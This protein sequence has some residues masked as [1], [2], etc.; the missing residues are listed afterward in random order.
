MNRSRMIAWTLVLGQLGVLCLTLGCS[1]RRDTVSG[2]VFLVTLG[3]ENVKL[4]LVEVRAIPEQAISRHLE[5]RRQQSDSACAVIAPRLTAARA[6]L[7]QA[8]SDLKRAPA[9][10]IAQE[11]RYIK[12]EITLEQ[13]GSRDAVIA[14]YRHAAEI[15]E[16][17]FELVD[18]EIRAAKSAAFML[19]GL[20]AGVARATTDADG[21]FSLSVPRGR[22]LA[23]AARA[24][25]LT[26]LGAEQSSWLFWLPEESRNGT[27]L[28]LSNGNTTSAGYPASLIQAE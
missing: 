3:R 27:P 17:R 15:A 26:F 6:L 2:Q 14:T 16:S 9:L 4:G 13:F 11:I 23:I 5:I 12:S 8:Q 21:R 22:K 10:A 20:P 28:Y 24:D 18:A 7:S 1:P 25:R 19:E